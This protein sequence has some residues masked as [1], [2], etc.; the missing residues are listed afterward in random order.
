[1]GTGD[2]TRDMSP[3]FPCLIASSGIKSTR[4]TCECRD[5]TC[6]SHVSGMC[7]VYVL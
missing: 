1:M 7:A 5:I 4:L 2:M 6:M 3:M